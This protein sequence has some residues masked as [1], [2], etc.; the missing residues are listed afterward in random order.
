MF[1]VTWDYLWQLKP[2]WWQSKSVWR[3]RTGLILGLES[4]PDGLLAPKDKIWCFQFFEV[5]SKLVVIGSSIS[6]LWSVSVIKVWLIAHDGL[7]ALSTWRCSQTERR[8]K[9]RVPL[10]GSRKKNYKP[11]PRNRSCCKLDI[12]SHHV[13]TLLGDLSGTLR[14]NM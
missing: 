6:V 4:P 2:H 7:F 12:K 5:S 9:F 13:N 1:K 10:F 14:F 3:E 11:W 8:F